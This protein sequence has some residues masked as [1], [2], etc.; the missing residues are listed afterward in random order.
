MASMSDA[1]IAQ[2]TVR[3]LREATV[4]VFHRLGGTAWLY[5]LARSNPKEY[6]KVLQRLLPQSIEQTVTVQPFVVPKHIA[7]L[8][9]DDLRA[10]RAQPQQQIIDVEFEEVRR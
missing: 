9:L 6:L 1:E 5:D 2:T 7:S 10:M 3:L 8:T 4:E